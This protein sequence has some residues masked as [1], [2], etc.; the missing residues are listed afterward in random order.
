MCGLAF[1]S[2]DNVLIGLERA[3]DAGVYKITDEIAL[4]QTVDFFTPVVDDPCLFGQIAVANALS[5]V[6]AMGG[7]PVCAMNVVCFPIG[8]MGVSVLRE[9]LRGGLIKMNEAEVSLVGGHSVEDQ[10]LKYGLSVAG[11]IHPEKVILNTGALVGDVLVLTKKLGTG[12]VNTA[13]KGDAASDTVVAD[14]TSYDDTGLTPSTQYCYRVRAANTAGESVFS[15]TAC[16]TTPPA[17][18]V[19][20]CTAYNDLAWVVG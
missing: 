2:D 7:R 17:T 15:N 12:I 5:D 4:V 1:P 3:D 13:V 16:A 9:I 18:L 11:I 8:T 6:Y 19:E 20:T 10:E 14:V